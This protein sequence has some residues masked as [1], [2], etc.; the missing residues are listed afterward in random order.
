MHVCI[1]IIS[2]VIDIEVV[3]I[4]NSYFLQIFILLFINNCLNIVLCLT[5]N[6]CHFIFVSF[7]FTDQSGDLFPR[8]S[9][10]KLSKYVM[11]T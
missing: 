9:E 10:L 7:R 8:D 3:L 1:S 5:L 2:L 6:E 4:F 11:W